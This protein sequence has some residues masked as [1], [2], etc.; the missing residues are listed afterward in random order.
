MIRIPGPIP[1]TITPMFWVL[2]ALIGFFSSGSLMGTLIWI[3]IIFVSVLFH[4]FGHALTARLFGLKPR[5]ELVAFGGVTYHE[6]TVRGF[7]KQFFIVF[8]G[9][10]FGFILFILASILVQIP[11][12]GQGMVGAILHTL[13]F[14]NLFWTVLNLLPVMP[15]DGGNLLRVTLEAIFGAKG[16]R[17][18]LL[19]STVLAVGFSLVAFLFQAF[20]VGA[21]FFLFAFQSYDLWKKTRHF[22]EKDRSDATKRAFEQA[23][24]ELLQGRKKEAMEIFERIRQETKEGMLYTLS[25]QYLAYLKAENGLTREAYDLLKPLQAELSEESLGVLHQVAFAEKDY[26]LVSELSGSC[27]RMAPGPEAALRNAMASASLGL[28]EAAIGWLQTALQ[29]GVQNLS[30]IVRESA[31][32]P[33]RADPQ[34]QQFVTAHL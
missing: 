32:D 16:F 9:P 2:A 33:I 7:W 23:E 4:E 14:V 13:Q 18:T 12:L 22:T 31:F 27:Y 17:Y 30:E 5:I 1:I 24:R 19:T 29:E 11:A 26:R 20:L 25:T 34:F 28:V 3:G 8:D 6:G 21:I 10:L 15:L